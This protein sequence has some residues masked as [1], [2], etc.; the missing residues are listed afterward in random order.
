MKFQNLVIASLILTMNAPAVFADDT[1]IIDTTTTEVAADTTTATTDTAS[2]TATDSV[3]PADI[4]APPAIGDTTTTADTASNTVTDTTTSTDT[5]APSTITTD[6]G[7]STLIESL[8][9]ASPEQRFEIMNQLKE[10]ISTLNADDRSSAI[11]QLRDS[12]PDRGEHRMR[13][14]D[15]MPMSP[16][17]N[18]NSQRGMMQERHGG[19]DERGEMMQNFGNMGSQMQENGGMQQDMMQ[20]QERMHDH[21]MDRGGRH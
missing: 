19:H 14:G 20:Q 2:N 18:M 17:E 11:S 10:L 6:N 1:A 7:V 3:A 9:S 8:K 5:L 21:M 15:D 4:P 13:E 12:R 16:N